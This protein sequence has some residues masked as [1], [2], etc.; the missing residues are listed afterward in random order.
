MIRNTL[1]ELLD[2]EGITAYSFS[3]TTGTERN[4]IYKIRD[5]KT[6]VP[7]SNLLIKICDFFQIEPGDF[8]IYDK[9]L[10]DASQL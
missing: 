6:V 9:S 5:N 2:K 7:H 10:K 8:I 1:K 4:T 3:K